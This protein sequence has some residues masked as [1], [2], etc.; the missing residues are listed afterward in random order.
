MGNSSEGME[1]RRRVGEPTASWQ[2]D[3]QCSN[4]ERQNIS[5]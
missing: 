3:P 4:D 2:R 1:R 5:V